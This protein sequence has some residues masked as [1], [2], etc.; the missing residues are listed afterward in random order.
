M[1][2]DV[3]LATIVRPDRLFRLVA[4]LGTLVI[5]KVERVS[6][7]ASHVLS[8]TSN[9]VL[10]QSNVYLV[11]DKPHLHRLALLYA[12]VSNQV[13]NFNR[14][15]VSVC[16]ELDTVR[17]Q[18]PTMLVSNISIQF[19]ERALIEMNKAIASLSKNSKTTV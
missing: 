12:H 8:I 18:R 17:T 15:I 14:R 6:C 16:V 11:V 7:L 9:I 1:L 5:S 19:V 13:E 4:H 2:I 3:L 10:V